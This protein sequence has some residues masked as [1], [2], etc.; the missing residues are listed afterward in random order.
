MRSKSYI[1]VRCNLDLARKFQTE[2]TFLST[3]C[4]VPPMQLKALRMDGFVKAVGKTAGKNRHQVNVWQVTD[5]F[6][7]AI[8]EL[9]R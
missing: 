5:L 3:A 2:H 6:R 8:K 1:W 9:P 4:P 7:D